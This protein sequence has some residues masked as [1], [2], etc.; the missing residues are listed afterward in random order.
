MLRDLRHADGGFFSA[1][2]ADSE[3]IEGKFYRGAST[4]S[5]RCAATTPTPRSSVLRRHRGGQ[6]PRTRTP[7]SPATS[8]TSSTAP[9]PDPTRSSSAIPRLFERRESRVRPGLDD[10]VLLG[11]NALFLRSLAEAAAA[12]D[13]ADWMDAA[14]DQRPLPRRVRCGATTAGSCGRGRPTAAPATSRSPRTTPRCSRRSAH[15]G[16][17]RRRR[18]A[19]RRPRRPPTPCSP[20]STTR[21]ARLLHHRRRR[22]GAHR[23]AAGLLRQRHPGRELARGRRAAPARRAHRRPHATRSA[24]RGV[25]RHPRRRPWPSTRALRL[26]LGAYE[27]AITP[28]I[29]IALVGAGDDPDRLRHEVFGRFIPA[30]VT[31]RTPSDG[32]RRRRAPPLLADRPLVDGRAT[33]YVCEEFACR[34]PVT[35]PERCAPRSTPRSPARRTGSTRRVAARERASVRS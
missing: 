2:D 7:A 22:R 5:P 20:A 18:V 24:R 3:G 30:S 23:P 29:E 25:P 13:R 21:R 14:A 17:G 6:L 34:L 28:P 10:K 33:A 1:E 35:D 16:R 27:R 31:V 15:P 32:R 9:R 19:R 8:S 4:S 26:L 11:W 12:L